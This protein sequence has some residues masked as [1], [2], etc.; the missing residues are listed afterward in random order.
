MLAYS[1][2]RYPS[3]VA[4]MVNSEDTT[5]PSHG[6]A[7]PA[8]RVMA[9]AIASSAVCAAL[10]LRVVHFDSPVTNID[11]ALWITKSSLRG[12]YYDMVVIWGLAVGCIIFLVYTS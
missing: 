12:S 11:S 7:E 8:M 5:Y 9:A 4:L 1:W 2:F 3:E 10:R 6:V